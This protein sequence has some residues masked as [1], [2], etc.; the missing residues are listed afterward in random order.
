MNK[1]AIASH[2]LFAA[3]ILAVLQLHL[4]PAAFAGFMVYSLTQKLSESVVHA[5]GARLP[6]HI[7]AAALA[8]VILV[9]VSAIA[10]FVFLA[11]HFIK[12]QDGLGWLMAHMADILERLRQSV[13]AAVQMYVPAS[14]DQVREM[15]AAAL[16][17][18]GEKLSAMG[19]DTARGLVHVLLGL[20]IGGM[21]AF[22]SFA[23]PD[24]YRPLSGELLKRASNL[25]VSFEQVV[26]AQVKISAVNTTLTA[27]YLIGVLPACGI[28]LPL[29]KTLIAV[30]FIAGL[31]PVVGNL[32]SNSIIV[33]LSLGLSFKVGLASLAFLVAV[34][35]LEYF[36]NARIIG[37]DIDAAAWELIVV[38]VAMEAIFGVPGLVSAPVL[39]AFLKRELRE[40]G[41]IG[42]LAQEKP[43]ASEG[44]SPSKVIPPVEPATSE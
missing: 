29:V 22:A 33:V 23:R 30:T 24:E 44:V 20:V 27:I 28:H 35:K 41:L 3:L 21:V 10:G 37:A 18:H 43:R 9:V 2:V 4:V 32:I 6:V 16:K 39:Y 38:M 40:A 19:M 36:L 13:P 26:F 11:I 25:L 15:A 34:H 7:K 5:H 31:L 42:R 8:T 17:T 1:P 12:G 14:V